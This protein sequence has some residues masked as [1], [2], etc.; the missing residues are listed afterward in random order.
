M[1]TLPGAYVPAPLRIFAGISTS[2][3][4]LVVA[5]LPASNAA[6][7]FLAPPEEKSPELVDAVRKALPGVAIEFPTSIGF[8]LD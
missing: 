3:T 7:I 5:F 2:L 4:W 8:R 1:F 6:G